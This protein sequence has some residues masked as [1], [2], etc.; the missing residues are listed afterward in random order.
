MDTDISPVKALSK[1]GQ[2]R[3]RRHL[4]GAFLDAC[5]SQGAA[6]SILTDGD[7]RVL[8]Y[9][10]LRRAAFALSSPIKDVTA[11]GGSVGIL[12]PTGAG[13]VIAMLSIH[14]AG[15]IPAMLNFTAGVKNLKA[16]AATAQIT[17]VVTAHKFVEIGGLQ[18]LI[19]DLSGD[20]EFLYLEDMRDELGTKAK[21]RAVLGP[22]LPK[23]FTPQPS[24]DDAGIILFTSGTEGLPKGVV[25]SHA[26][27][28]ANIRQIYS[29]IRC[30]LFIA[31]A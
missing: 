8:S 20:V 12:L 25:L 17:H 22:Y 5:R 6:T 27:I 18:D 28:L 10:D 19:K 24:P 11:K 16:A 1:R 13:A 21:L 31:T 2:R 30:R 14:A 23:L 7:E 3:T 26:N 29:L 4:F 9:G 15:R